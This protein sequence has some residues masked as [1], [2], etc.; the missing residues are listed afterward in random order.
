M[1]LKRKPQES[2][3]VRFH[4]SWVDGEIAIPHMKDMPMSAVGSLHR[5]D[6]SP[7]ITW[8]PED[9]GTLVEDATVREIEEFMAAWSKAGDEID[10]L[11]KHANSLTSWLWGRRE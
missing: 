10:A 3:A 8:L 4:V 1:T 11:A 6:W 5:N 7:L 2:Q 9:V